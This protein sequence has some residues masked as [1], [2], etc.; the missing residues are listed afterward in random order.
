MNGYPQAVQ[1]LNFSVELSRIGPELRVAQTQYQS[2][3]QVL[4]KAWVSRMVEASADISG[5]EPLLWTKPVRAL[6]LLLLKDLPKPPDKRFGLSGMAGSH[7]AALYEVVIR[8]KAKSGGKSW[9]QKM[10]TDPKNTAE[11]P[12]PSM[13]F[14][15][16]RTGGR[17]CVRLGPHWDQTKVAMTLDGKPLSTADYPEL[18]RH[19]ANWDAGSESESSLAPLTARLEL[20]V[21]N[22]ATGKFTSASDEPSLLPVKDRDELQIRTDLSRSAYI[23]LI[24]LDQHGQPFPMY[25]WNWRRGDWSK[26]PAF[27]LSNKVTVPEELSP[28]GHSDLIVSGPPGVETLILL[29]SLEIPTAGTLRGLAGLLCIAPPSIKPEELKGPAISMRVKSPASPKKGS[30]TRTPMVRDCKD[31][32]EALHAALAEPLLNNGFDCVT[33]LTFANAGPASRAVRRTKG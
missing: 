28:A 29:A 2:Y 10:F 19:L 9:I 6:L 11:Q 32:V 26:S 7:A 13:L 3:N 30:A 23:C 16:S 17:F 27:Q 5:C 8:S 18:A 12:L 1:G 31:P 33:L 14:R 4:K 15:H 22:P 25:P 20:L 24:W 21:R